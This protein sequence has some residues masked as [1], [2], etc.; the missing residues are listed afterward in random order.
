MNRKAYRMPVFNSP[1][2][3]LRYIHENY[4]SEIPYGEFLLLAKTAGKG[5]LDLVELIFKKEKEED[6]LAKLS[7]IKLNYYE[8]LKKAYVKTSSAK[9][10]PIITNNISPLEFYGGDF[11][12]EKELKEIVGD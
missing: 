7:S 3:A 1:N 9:A 4:F 12:L 10:L 2:E 8:E 5:F 11:L 6:R